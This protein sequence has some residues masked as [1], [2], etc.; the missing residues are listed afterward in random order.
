MPAITVSRSRSAKSE[1]APDEAVDRVELIQADNALLSLRASGHDYCS[2][3]GEVF[4]NSIQ[5]K[6]NNIRLKLFTDKRVIGA[7]TKK[8]EV[9]D[10]LAIGD[11]GDGMDATAGG[12]AGIRRWHRREHRLADLRRQQRF[13]GSRPKVHSLE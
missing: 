3:I 11:D 7:N 4:D 5:A 13:D 2:A 9:V 1:A 10:R 8:T 12:G 6:A